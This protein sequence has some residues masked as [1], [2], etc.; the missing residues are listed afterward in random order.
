MRDF[1]VDVVFVMV[2]IGF[3]VLWVE[4]LAIRTARIDAQDACNGVAQVEAAHRQRLDALEHDLSAALETIDDHRREIDWILYDL[5]K[6][7][8]AL[9]EEVEHYRRCEVTGK[10]VAGKAK[11]PGCE[12]VWV[13]DHAEIK[14]FEPKPTPPAIEV[15]RLGSG[16]DSGFSVSGGTSTINITPT[17][18]C[19]DTSAVSSS[20]GACGP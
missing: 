19:V 18:Y 3:G 1:R 9:D 15:I 11:C 7:L 14:H 20:W 17:V 6:K 2:A 8:H 5:E 10:P 16:I 12:V 13:Y 4:A